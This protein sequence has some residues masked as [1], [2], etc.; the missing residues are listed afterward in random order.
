MGWV[1]PG[2]TSARNRTS[3]LYA[4]V[5]STT[6]ATNQTTVDRNR[7]FFLSSIIRHLKEDAK[8]MDWLPRIEIAFDSTQ[9]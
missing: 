3:N 7:R 2:P 8:P 6:T 1:R 9:G 4:N 5:A